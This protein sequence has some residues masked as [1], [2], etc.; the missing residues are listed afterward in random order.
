MNREIRVCICRSWH[1]S[2]RPWLMQF[3]QM[4]GERKF[5]SSLLGARQNQTATI[6]KIIP[7]RFFSK[8]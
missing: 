4:S 8:P 5:G 7:L 2:D 3:N 1:L 6:L